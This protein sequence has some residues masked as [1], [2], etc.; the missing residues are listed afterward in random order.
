MQGTPIP[1]TVPT[2]PPGDSPSIFLEKKNKKKTDYYIPTWMG[3]LGTEWEGVWVW[4]VLDIINL[5]GHLGV[6]WEYLGVA[7]R[8]GGV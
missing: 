1:N 3:L 8:V 5:N 7:G 4:G 2:F 6:L